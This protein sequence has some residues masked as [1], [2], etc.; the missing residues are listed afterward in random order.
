MIALS[1]LK[2][3]LEFTD[4]LSNI[5][6]LL[7]TAAVFQFNYFQQRARPSEEFLAQAAACF[8]ELSR[9]GDSPFVQPRAKLPSVIAVITSEEGFLGELNTLLVNEALARRS[10]PQDQVIVLGEHGARYLEEM[11]VGFMFFPGISDEVRRQ[12]IEGLAGYLLND[13][14][15]KF[16]R[17]LVV[18][19]RF[20]S[21]AVQRVEVFQ[22][23]PYENSSLSAKHRIGRRGDTIIEPSLQRVMAVMVK[24]WMNFTLL[25][26]FWSSKQSE[27][28][29]RI[30]HLETSTQ[31]LADL[32]KTL[33]FNYF[34]QVHELRDITIRE[35]SASKL[36]AGKRAQ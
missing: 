16:G 6:D 1:Q 22:L 2:T 28:A 34:R 13:F 9:Y 33:A 36:M 3:E 24:L 35:I 25:D 26:I 5:I 18:Y 11:N 4:D 14:R 31:E 10:S 19:P 23:L 8:D 20:V 30:M 12:E 17:I 32:Q 21:L 29:A 7:K 15:Q 27:Y